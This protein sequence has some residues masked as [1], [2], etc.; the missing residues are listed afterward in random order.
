LAVEIGDPEFG[1]FGGDHW[2]FMSASWVPLYGYG[3]TMRG[4]ACRLLQIGC[5]PE[6]CN[7]G[8]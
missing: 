7:S 1:C 5:K 3:L 2:G 6:L 8:R 4:A